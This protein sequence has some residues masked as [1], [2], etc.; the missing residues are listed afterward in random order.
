MP[1][2]MVISDEECARI[3]E[4]CKEKSRREVAEE[5][6]WNSKR[7]HNILQRYKRNQSKIA[8]PL[9]KKELPPCKPIKITSIEQSTPPESSGKAMVI[10]TSDIAMIKKLIGDL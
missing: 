8:K 9:L 5:M 2:K 10:I 7:I 1:R 4:K 6:G 3:A